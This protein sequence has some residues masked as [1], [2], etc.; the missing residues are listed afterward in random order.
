[1]S[2]YTFFEP[3]RFDPANEQEFETKLKAALHSPPSNERLKEIALAVIENYSWQKT[4]EKFYQLLNP[5]VQ[6]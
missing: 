6:I 5:S 4:A 3:Y 2:D 1:M